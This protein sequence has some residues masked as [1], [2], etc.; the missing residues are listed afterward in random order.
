[1][2]AAV[3]QINVVTREDVI[4]VNVREDVVTTRE[5]GAADF[6]TIVRPETIVQREV[7]YEFVEIGTPGPQGPSGLGVLDT[8]LTED[9]ALIYQTVKLL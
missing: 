6:V 7:A 9:P 3:D 1:M 4:T 8:K 2:S 5:A